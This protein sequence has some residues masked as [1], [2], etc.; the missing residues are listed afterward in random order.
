MQDVRKAGTRLAPLQP[1]PPPPSGRSGL[2]AQRPYAAPSR[3]RNIAGLQ[4]KSYARQ[5]AA[6]A[7]S[8]AQSRSRQAGGSRLGVEDMGGAAA[9]RTTTATGHRRATHRRDTTDRAAHRADGEHAAGHGH[10]AATSSGADRETTADGGNTRPPGR[11]ADGS[12]PTYDAA[13]ALLVG[14]ALQPSWHGH[15]GGACNTHT[16]NN[17]CHRRR[18]TTATA[19]LQ[20]PVHRH[21]T[22]SQHQWEASAS[23]TAATWSTSARPSGPPPTR[24]PDLLPT[25]HPVPLPTHPDPGAAAESTHSLVRSATSIQRTHT[26]PKQPAE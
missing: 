8:P 20:Q 2:L 16:A 1:V 9:R 11:Q 19:Q 6:P 15:D 22:S 18:P 13:Q 10:A 25:R 5:P 17:S 12:G 24:L 26:R 7:H 3:Q 21:L 14:S 4:G 23:T